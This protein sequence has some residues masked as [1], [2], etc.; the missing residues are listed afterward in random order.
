[1]IG[2]TIGNYVVR[3]KIGEGGM[4]VVYV[5]E[6]PRIGRKVA[7]KVLLPEYSQN[8]DVVARF[9][10]EARASSAIKNEH[11][12]DI[13]DFGELA[14][15]SSYIIMEWLE[16]RPLTAVLGSEGKLSVERAL[17]VARGIGRALAAAHGR[18]IV[19]RDLKPDN[20]FLVQ[21]GDDPEFVKVL[22]FG[23]AKLLGPD[24]KDGGAGAAKLASKTRTGA[25][26]GTPMYMSPEQ[27]RGVAVDERSDIYSLGVIGYQMLTGKV[28]FEAEGLGELLLKHMTEPPQPLRELVPTL[29][30]NVERAVLRALAKEPDKR[31]ARVEDF[32]AELGGQVTAPIVAQRET[33]PVR[34][35]APTAAVH[36][37]A[38]AT[39]T[40]GAAAGE[41]IAGTQPPP[42]RSGMVWFAV[43]ALGLATVA[44]VI[45]LKDP[46]GAGGSGEPVS[47]GTARPAPAAKVE[48]A[49]PVPV[50][51]AP[52][53]PA[54]ALLE[55]RATPADARITIDGTVQQN[56]YAAEL[57]RDGHAY[58]VEISAAGYVSHR[59]T[60]TL[61]QPRTVAAVLAPESAS[62][63]TPDKKGS[64]R[65]DVKLPAPPPGTQDPKP[66]AKSDAPAA[67]RPDAKPDAKTDAKPAK[68]AASTDDNTYKGTK[69]KL[70]TDFPP[71]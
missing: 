3:D 68:K 21:R 43:P 9:F 36:A 61:D 52:P 10:T 62:A 25:I 27:C 13:I 53:P 34:A 26:I 69:A 66:V 49:T 50:P 8:P 63:R 38:T 30:E 22:D 64:K 55:V 60:V 11:I 4:G 16:G 48:S 14:D 28:P 65:H 5:A 29:P 18:G 44:A 39:D 58:V 71:E 20:V 70:I 31:Q 1:V 40:I 67:P 54:R 7:I 35:P 24:T 33:G 23:I 41:T 12:I 47:A 19:H 42:G 17:H 56:P 46:R 51:T 2:T 57:V 15:G 59:E 6:H 32:V 37:T 45:L